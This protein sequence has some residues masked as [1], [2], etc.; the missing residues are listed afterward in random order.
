MRFSPRDYQRDIIKFI[1]ATPRCGVFAGMGT[2]KSSATLQALLELSLVE[3][4]FPALVLAPL[5]VARSTWP[6]EVTKWD[7]PLAIVPVIGSAQERTS[8]LKRVADIYTTNYENLVWLREHLGDAWPF[9]T[10][11]ADELT[12]LKGFRLRQGGTRARALGQVAHTHVTRF[13]GLTGTP[14]GNGI[15]DLYGQAWFI[16]Q[17]SRLGRTHSAFTNRWF[18]PKYNGFGLEPLPHAQKE[19]QDLLRDVCITITAADYMDLPPLVENT[20]LVDLPPGAR[21]LYRDME[22]EMFAEIGEDGIE[23]F[24][25]AS[26]TNKCLQIAAGAAYI[27]EHGAWEEIHDAKLKALEDIVE[28]AAGMPVLVS[29]QFK[30]DLARILKHFGKRARALDHKPQTLK[31]WNAGKIDVLCAHP[32]SAGHG[33]NLQHGSNI[34]AYFSSGWN[35]E[36]DMQILERIGPTRQAQAGLNREVYVHRIVARNTVDE[37]VAERREGKKTVQEILLEAMKRKSTCQP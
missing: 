15:A 24:N 14:C 27:D 16:D 10:V 12:K 35:L 5:R 11:V 34:I 3:D 13:I 25:A 29:Y 18:R 28:E 2:G 21:K 6:D 4:V 19:I 23:A 30:S 20:I 7:F 22:K 36:E 9:K 37:M 33:L 26:R 8:A 17:G 32:A 31:D 1:Q